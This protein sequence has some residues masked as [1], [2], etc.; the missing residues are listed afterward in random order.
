MNYISEHIQGHTFPKGGIQL[1]MSILNK[2]L[3]SPLIYDVMNQMHEELFLVQSETL[4]YH[5]SK[6]LTVFL[7]TYKLSDKA[8]E[9]H[10]KRIISSIEHPY[11]TGRLCQLDLL[12]NVIQ[13]FPSNVAIVYCDLIYIQL[14]KQLSNET[15]S[16]AKKKIIQTIAILL[17]KIDSSKFYK[18]F[19]MCI[20]WITPNNDG[21]VK[22]KDYDIIITALQV[23]GAFMQQNKIILD[24][25]RIATI[26]KNIVIHI[27]MCIEQHTS[28]IKINDYGDNIVWKPC[29]LSLI[30]YDKILKYLKDNHCEYL[31]RNKNK[32]YQNLFDKILI[33]IDYPHRWIRI[34]IQRILKYYLNDIDLKIGWIQN[35]IKHLYDLSQKLCDILRDLY[36][37]NSLCQVTLDNLLHLTILLNNICSKNIAQSQ[38]NLEWVKKLKRKQQEL[39]QQKIEEEKL[40]KQELQKKR[41]NAIKQMKNEIKKIRKE[42]ENWFDNIDWNESDTKN[43]QNIQN[44]MENWMNTNTDIKD[45]LSDMNSDDDDDDVSDV[46]DA[47]APDVDTDIKADKANDD[48]K[49]G[50]TEVE[51]IANDLGIG[52]NMKKMDDMDDDN[53]INTDNWMINEIFMFNLHRIKYR[54]TGFDIRSHILNWFFQICNQLNPYDLKFYDWFIIKACMWIINVND[55]RKNIEIKYNIMKL[56]YI[57]SDIN[58]SN[59]DKYIIDNYLDCINISNKILNIVKNKIGHNSYFHKINEAKKRLQFFDENNNKKRKLNDGNSVNINTNENKINDWEQFLW[60]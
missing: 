45:D 11:L 7:L 41:K 30:V 9:K 20:Q 56:K 16:I 3:Q 14:M 17:E 39:Y 46:P 26:V 24:K 6:C 32:I 19:D 49:R 38:N 53:D 44:T 21:N 42:K 4:T 54:G 57:H 13:S 37:T 25:H 27:E 18:L 35:D 23:I 28:I 10:M 48:E 55:P 59:D 34:V 58:I 51:W 2:R 22:G 5:Y 36:I 12:Q 15:E 29:Y 50:L 47:D 8:I 40:S 52:L 43:E 1:L 33:I 60:S 31:M